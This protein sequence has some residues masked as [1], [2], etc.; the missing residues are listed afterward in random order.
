MVNVSAPTNPSTNPAIAS[1]LPCWV[2]PEDLICRSE[3]AP[4]MIAS[5]DP[6]QKIQMMPRTSEAIARPLV[7]AF[8]WPYPYGPGGPP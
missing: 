1:P 6:S 7:P 3:I 2:L 8:C 5:S 4:K